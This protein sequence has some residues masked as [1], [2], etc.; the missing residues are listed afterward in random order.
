M[1]SDR[2]DVWGCKKSESDLNQLWADEMNG[3]VPEGTYRKEL[4][5][6][7]PSPKDDEKEG[8]DE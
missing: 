6:Q 3:K 8:K 4:M 7:Y 1:Y 2:A 5:K